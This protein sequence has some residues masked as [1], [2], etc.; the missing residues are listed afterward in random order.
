V[1]HTF[2]IDSGRWILEGNW[3]ERDSSPIPVKGKTIVDW[4]QNDWFVLA[5]KLVFPQ[6][7]NT[8]QEHP[9]ITL[10]YRGRFNGG[11]R[12]YSFVLQHSQLGQVE[13]EGWVTPGAIIQRYW[14][15]NDPERRSGFDT[16]HRLSNHQY[17]LASGITA[18]HYLINTMEA[19]LDRQL[20]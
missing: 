1:A 7:F 20:S 9:A 12:R 11:D 19:T 5:T 13:G 18:G 16:L 6:N 10:Q 14:S 8:C 4:S 17:Y 15:I 3:L 2:L